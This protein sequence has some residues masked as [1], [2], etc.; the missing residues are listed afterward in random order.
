M[1]EEYTEE[2]MKALLDHHLK[3]YG[4]DG[5]FDIEDEMFKESYN[6]YIKVV[7]PIIVKIFNDKKHDT[8]REKRIKEFGFK[9]WVAIQTLTLFN[10]GFHEGAG[11]VVDELEK[12]TN[13]NR[14]KPSYIG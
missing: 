7:L 11:K 9:G 1:T 14:I 12:I 2:K 5:S 13:K 4:K 8:H 10:I 6:Q 3:K